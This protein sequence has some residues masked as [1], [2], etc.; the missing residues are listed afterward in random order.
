MKKIDNKKSQIVIYQSLADGQKISVRIE[1][2][3]VWLSQKTIAE[4]YAV[5]VRTVNEHLKNIYF[6][7]ELEENSVIRNFRI[8]AADGKMYDA[9]HYNLDAILAVGYRVRSE[10]GTQF[11]QWATERLR[12][13]LIKGFTMDDERLKQ[14]GGR[15]RYFQELLQRVRDIRSSERMFYQKVTDIYATSIDYKA[16]A[17]LTKKFFAIVQNKMHYAVHGYTAAEVIAKRADSKK[18]LMG[19]TSFKGDYITV[20]D[21]KVAKNYLT[22]AEIKQLNLVVSLYI[23]FAELQASNG[24]LMKMNDWIKKLDEFLSASEKNLLLSAGKVSAEQAEKAARQEY[25]KYRQ[26]QDKKYISD[27]DREVKKILKN[28]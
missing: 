28:K 16:D 27:F 12:E 11:R 14:G 1:D 3:N 24:R 18:P 15:A 2:E 25:E 21:I 6:E 20:D 19:L 23:D 5:D 9:K 10:R 8:T 13:Y 7:R 26:E 4:L 17:S 22:E